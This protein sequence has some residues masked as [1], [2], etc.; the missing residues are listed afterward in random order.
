MLWI[1]LLT[2]LI[3]LFLV[4]CL[5][6]VFDLM[7]LN[8]SF[9][10]FWVLVLK[11]LST[12]HKNKITSHVSSSTSMVEFLNFKSLI[13]DFPLVEGIRERDIVDF[14]PDGYP[15]VPTLLT[16]YHTLASYQH[17]VHTRHSTYYVLVFSL[18]PHVP[19]PSLN[20]FTLIYNKINLP[21]SKISWLLLLIF[22]INFRTVCLVPK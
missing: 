16:F 3:A 11:V 19:M 22:Q 10:S 20:Y 6:K 12:P 5:I 15:V 17:V 14:S 1:C 9:N 13:P 2:L 8:L 18:F 4:F 7:L 21:F